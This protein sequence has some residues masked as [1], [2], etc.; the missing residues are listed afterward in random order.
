M[1]SLKKGGDFI[2]ILITSTILKTDYYFFLNEI[3]SSPLSIGTILKSVTA[4]K[5]FYWPKHFFTKRPKN[6]H[7]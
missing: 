5:K 2:S 4:A 6:D 1:F 7:F 3:A